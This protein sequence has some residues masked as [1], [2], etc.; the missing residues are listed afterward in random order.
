MNSGIHD[1]SQADMLGRQYH[2]YDHRSRQPA[3]RMSFRLPLGSCNSTAPVDAWLVGPFE[4]DITKLLPGPPGR[5]ENSPVT[6]AAALLDRAFLL[7]GE[8]LRASRVP[9]FESGRVLLMRPPTDQWSD[10]EATILLPIIDNVPAR[11]LI[12]LFKSVVELV[13]NRLVAPLGEKEIDAVFSEVARTIIDPLSAK[14]PFNLSTLATCQLAFA[15]DIP[16]R[17]IGSGLIMVGLGSRS[18]LMRGAAST[19][20]SALGAQVCSHKPVTAN[21]LAD[22]GLPAAEHLVV[23]SKMEALAAA[24]QLGWPVVAKPANQERS[25]GVTIN[26]E[27]ESALIAAYEHASVDGSLV[28]IER[29][30]PGYCHRIMVAN[31]EL[32]YAVIRYPKG[33]IGNGVD[34]VAQLA[35]KANAEQAHRPPWKRLK[36][37][38]VDETA[39]QCLAGQQLEL[40]D[41]PA[42]GRRI[43]M[44]DISSGEWGGDVENLTSKIHPENVELALAAARQARLTVAGI[45]LMSV[46]ISQPWHK[47]GAAIIE[48]NYNPEF[49]IVGRESE[50]AKLLPALIKGDGRVP[51]HLVTGQGD[52]LKHGK[53]IQRT[54]NDQ[55]QNLYLTT[56]RCTFDP[57]GREI[58][59]PF[60]TLL[61]R[62]LS[63]VMRTDVSGLILV[64]TDGDLFDCGL[65]V[66]R[67]DSVTILGHGPKRRER[68]SAK[69][70]SRFAVT[71]LDELK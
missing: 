60:N 43:F 13:L 19:S 20:D 61:E 15:H 49:S 14:L 65:A 63:L 17:H 52:L 30:Q 4:I 26:I 56:A 39:L 16:F 31:G 18:T 11:P 22:A 68:L 10:P 70:R 37:V 62:S 48:V 46:D 40:T 29:Q 41:V 25:I 27:T 53:T 64:G 45:D 33:V 69:I 36:D 67:L 58:S 7:F 50:T 3:I 34:T 57:I 44:R 9:C 42:K 59:L 55:A 54:L 6:L 32:I 28:V 2:G 51:V 1:L 35:T 8:L 5:D 47:N 12:Q 66:D 71:S 24:L 23:H 38:P 21:I